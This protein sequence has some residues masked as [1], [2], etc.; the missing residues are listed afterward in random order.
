VI[1]K[2]LPRSTSSI[3]VGGDKAAWVTASAVSYLLGYYVQF[4]R[5]ADA[6]IHSPDPLGEVTVSWVLENGCGFSV[7]ELD[8]ALET[9]LVIVSERDKRPGYYRFGGVP[10]RYSL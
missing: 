6:F 8:L 3:R 10:L 1:F 4:R 9:A 2:H 7:A 5:H